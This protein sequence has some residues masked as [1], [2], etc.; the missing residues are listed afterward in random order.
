MSYTITEKGTVTIPAEVRSKYDLKKGS[1]VKF[2][3]TDEGVLIVPI[4]PIEELFGVDSDKKEMVRQMIK[5]IQEERKKE[6][7]EEK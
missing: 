4:V 5:E 2:V 6:T 3:E 7:I 1:K